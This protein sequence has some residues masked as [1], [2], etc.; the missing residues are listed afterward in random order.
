MIDI[1]PVNKY[2]HRKVVVSTD[3]DCFIVYRE[4]KDAIMIWVNALSVEEGKEL[5]TVYNKAT[6]IMFGR[7]LKD[8]TQK[9][10]DDGTE[11]IGNFDGESLYRFL[12]GCDIKISREEC[13]EILDIVFSDI[14]KKRELKKERKK[15]G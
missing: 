8:V 9:H 15:I 2:D 1:L 7:Y 13:D 14:C 3:N 6:A 4:K 5:V 12:T 10:K 11:G